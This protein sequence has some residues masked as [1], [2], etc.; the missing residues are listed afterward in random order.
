MS[1]K[2]TPGAPAGGEDDDA[3]NSNV[4]LGIVFGMLGLVLM[5][6]LDDTRVAGLPFLVLGITFFVM[7]IRSRTGGTAT[8]ADAPD[9]DAR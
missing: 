3:T 7:G 6:T 4:A 9:D 2:T 1:E 5:L 8:A